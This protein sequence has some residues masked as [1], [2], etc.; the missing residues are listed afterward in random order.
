M[1]KAAQVA[2]FVIHDFIQSPRKT[3]CE[4]LGQQEI[5]SQKNQLFLR[6][7]QDGHETVGDFVLFMYK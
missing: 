5:D 1:A 6:W 4:P 7:F 3:A 2:G